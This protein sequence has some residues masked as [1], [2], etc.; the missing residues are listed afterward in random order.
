MH[1][2]DDDGAAPLYIKTQA[3]YYN[4]VELLLGAGAELN[5]EHYEGTTPF[6]FTSIGSQGNCGG[7]S[8]RSGGSS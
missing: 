2:T 1:Q 7:E 8:A 6:Y 5:Q 4:V 3:D